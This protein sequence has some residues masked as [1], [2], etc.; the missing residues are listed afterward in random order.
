M[1]STKN[2]V[3]TDWKEQAR[4]LDKSVKVINFR[5]YSFVLYRAIEE[6]K[7]LEIWKENFYGPD[8]HFT[9]GKKNEIVEEPTYNV[10]PDFELFTKYIYCL[11]DGS[12]RLI[13]VILKF[14]RKYVDAKKVNKDIRKV[15]G[16]RKNTMYQVDI[17]KSSM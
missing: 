5:I 16:N 7:G 15:I 17:V 2:N 12:F 14:G 11:I 9:F 10:R 1:K 4:L 13:G 6:D 8:K 3:N